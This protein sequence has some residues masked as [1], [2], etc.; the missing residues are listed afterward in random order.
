MSSCNDLRETRQRRLSM[1]RI[2][3]LLGC[4][5]A[6]S[7]AAVS[8]CG[9]SSAEPMSD[10][11]KDP[12]SSR[13]SG[14]SG[15]KTQAE[16]EESSLD[17]ETSPEPNATPDSDGPSTLN[18]PVL[19]R[20]N[21]IVSHMFTADAS[22]HVWEDGRLYLY[23]STDTSPPNGYGTMDG[24]H[25]FS[26]DDLITWE[27]HGEIL[28][29]D[30]VAWGREAGGYMWA[31]DCAEKDGTYYYYYPHRD[32][33]NVWQIGV[34]TSSGPTSG[35]TDQGYIEGLLPLIDPAVLIDDD[36]TAYLYSGGPGGPHAVKLTD[37]MLEAD[38][39]QQ[40]LQGLPSFKEG[41]WV[42]RRE[43]IYYAMYPDNTKPSALMHYAMS[44]NPLGPFEYQGVFLEG[45]DVVTTH[46][47][48]L[49]FKDEWYLFYHNGELSG[50]QEHNRSVSFDLVHFNNDGTIQMVEQTLGS[51]LPAFHEDVNFNRPFGM[52]DVG[53]YL[54]ADLK[55]RGIEDDAIS[56]IEIPAGF[57]V[58]CFEGDQFAGKSWLLKTGNIDLGALGCDDT[59]SSLKITQTPMT[60]LV[61]NGSFEEGV[62]GTI[63]HW[64]YAGSTPIP[65]RALT[66]SE[67]GYYSLRYEKNRRGFTIAQSVSV[68]PN[69]DYTVSVSMK[70]DADTLGQVLLTVGSQSVVSDT[71]ALDDEQSDGQ[72]V[73]LTKTI[74]SGDNSTL[75][76]TCVTSEDFSGTAYWDD[77]TMVPQ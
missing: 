6:L 16:G 64:R 38:G 61:Q 11:D 34:A 46:G 33:Q 69:T 77:V 56:S 32:A 63:S 68:T 17:P 41:L 1:M 62:Q 20:S 42:F 49:E 40:T 76:L 13:A 4:S 23:P 37:N 74:D 70:L 2:R 53:E 44:D 54:Q 57:S 55:D 72:W 19:R 75:Y 36:G 48:I 15:A 12:D 25:V 66:T 65:V 31:P 9:N 59:C 10:L 30:D 73:R 50:G 51:P 18:Q 71:L 45:T 58:E 52:L 3:S 28:H 29:S 24:Y 14:G 43:G 39:E 27:D 7:V 26:T 47:S 21:P 35:F 67:D 22:A 5:M 60:S 8:G